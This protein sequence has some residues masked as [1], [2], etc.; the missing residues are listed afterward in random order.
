VID[1]RG[2]V[3]KPLRHWQPFHIRGK[4]IHFGYNVCAQWQPGGTTLINVM[5]GATWFYSIEQA[6]RGADILLEAGGRATPPF[7]GISGVAA[8]FWIL[9]HKEF[10]S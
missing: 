3:I 6:K 1:Y 7:D 4:L 2:F 8:R 10:P 5:P 9:M